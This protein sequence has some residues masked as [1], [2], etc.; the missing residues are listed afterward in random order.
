MIK[1]VWWD[2]AQV[3]FEF[4]QIRDCF[5][6]VPENEREEDIL[7]WTPSS[8][9]NWFMWFF[10]WC[11]WKWYSTTDTA[12]GRPPHIIFVRHTNITHKLIP[13]LVSCFERSSKF[14]PFIC[15]KMVVL[16]HGPFFIYWSKFS[17]M[18]NLSYLLFS[19][20]HDK[21]KFWSTTCRT[22]LGMSCF[23]Y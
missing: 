17:S 7:G 15:N 20:I 14:W 8:V 10:R 1:I 9:I 6:Y 23:N 4:L 19:T 21:P 12:I 3:E 11:N 2:P 13:V 5:W 22:E 18:S 16:Y